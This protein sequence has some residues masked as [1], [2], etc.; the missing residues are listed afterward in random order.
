MPDDQKILAELKKCMKD[1]S[2]DADCM[3][4]CQTTFDAAGG[5]TEEGKV[6]IT[7]DG[8][9]AFVTKNGKVFSGGKVF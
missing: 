6:F 5:T 7:P 4:T 1:C 3:A 8:S 2:G 9:T